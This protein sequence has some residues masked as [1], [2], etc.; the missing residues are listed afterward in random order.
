MSMPTFLLTLA[1]AIAATPAYADTPPPPRPPD[2]PRLVDIEVKDQ[3]KMGAASAHFVLAVAANGQPSTL[4]SA[5]G[6]ATYSIKVRHDVPSG[7][8]S[9]SVELERRVVH[10]SGPML[11]A[12]LQIFAVRTLAPDKREVVAA[13]ERQDGSQ[14]EV[15]MTLH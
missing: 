12:E 5:I 11:P 4:G 14:T 9:Y 7:I 6:D 10:R 15:A 3:E 2:E 8:L 13:I 1:A